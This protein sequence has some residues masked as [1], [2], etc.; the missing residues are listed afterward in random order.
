[1]STLQLKSTKL[2]F[3]ML[4]FV[5]SLFANTAPIF[6]LNNH[7][8]SV[9][10]NIN[11]NSIPK[12]ASDIDIAV[13]TNNTIYAVYRNG[14]YPSNSIYIKKLVDKNL[15]I[16]EQNINDHLDTANIPDVDL[17][18]RTSGE[19]RVSNFLLWQ[20]AYAEMFFTQTYWPEFNKNELDDILSDFGK[21]ERR[22]GGI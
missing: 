17:L 5:S 3:L 1:M 13:D 4:I 14:V 20:I 12:N 19:I 2:L 16:T 8:E 11:N 6:N 22:F 21:R 10:I 15:E 18:V 7:K 9:W